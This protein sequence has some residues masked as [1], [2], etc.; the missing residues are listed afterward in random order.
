M[1]Q[2]IDDRFAC[3]MILFTALLFRPSFDSLPHDV[4]VYGQAS[5]GQ[6]K[7]ARGVCRRVK[8]HGATRSFGRRGSGVFSFTTG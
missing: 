2:T 3:Q 4:A 5:R 7:L 6:P 8:G 1:C